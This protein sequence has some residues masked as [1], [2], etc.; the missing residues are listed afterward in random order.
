[1]HVPAADLLTE[2]VLLLYLYDVYIIIMVE[3]V[4][5]FYINTLKKE[6]ILLLIY[7]TSSLSFGIF[8]TFSKSSSVTHPS[9]LSAHLHK[10]R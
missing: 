6:T 10:R 1:M 5:L 2:K 4:V 3:H 8:K 7:C 9:H